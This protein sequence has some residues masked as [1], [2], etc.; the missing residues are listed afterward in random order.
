MALR[1]GSVTARG[2]RPAS[3]LNPFAALKRRSSTVVRVCGTTEEFAEK[4]EEHARSLPQALK[5]GFI[6]ND[7]TARMN[8][9]PSRTC[10]NWSFSATSE[11]VPFPIPPFPIRI[12]SRFRFPQG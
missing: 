2:L 8:S 10:S 11:V 1:G 3:R 4:P 5:R 9:C 6:F 7:L 12:D